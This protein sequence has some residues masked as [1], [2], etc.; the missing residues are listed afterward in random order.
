MINIHLWKIIRYNSLNRARQILP[1][2]RHASHP[3]KMRGSSAL[4]QSSSQR[5]QHL[6]DVKHST[7]ASKFVSVIPSA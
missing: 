7:A 2:S 6:P 3:V 4:N 1:P 5:S